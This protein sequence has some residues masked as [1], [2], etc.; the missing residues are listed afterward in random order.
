MHVFRTIWLF[1]GLLIITRL[2]RHNRSVVLLTALI[3]ICLPELTR[4]Y[5]FDLSELYAWQIPGLF[6]GWYVARRLFATRLFT[7]D[8]K[9]SVRIPTLLWGVALFGVSFL[10][11]WTSVASGPFLCFLVALEAARADLTSS[12]NSASKW[13]RAKYVLGFALVALGMFGERLLRTAYHTYCLKRWGYENRTQMA[14]DFGHLRENLAAQIHTYLKFSLWPVTIIPAALLLIL[15]LLFTY[16]CWKKTIEP[17][18]ELRRIL[19]DDTLTLII[20]MWGVGL[21]NFVMSATIVH[22]RLMSYETRFQTLPWFLGVS[23]GLLTL[24]WVTRHLLE[25]SPLR[26][27]YLR[28]VTVAVFL[29]LLFA[30]PAPTVS[31]DYLIDQKTATTLAERA[32]EATLMGRYWDTY[33]LIALQKTS[34]MLPL[35]LQGEPLRMPWTPATLPDAKQVIVEYRRSNISSSHSAPPI[36]IQYGETLRLVEPNWYAN[37]KYAFALYLNDKK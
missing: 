19:M 18:R 3:A 22:V 30:F 33:I 26:L 11:I 31:P 4:I 27:H 14:L 25:I 34:A 35:P 20:G 37:E 16:R 24:I 10:T 17:L 36:I 6:L 8:S 15:V 9:I 23:S 13:E 29:F 2:V 5:V 28:L 7:T 1:A 32:P 21:I 12:D